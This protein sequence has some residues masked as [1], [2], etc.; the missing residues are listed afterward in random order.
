MKWLVS[1]L[2]LFDVSTTGERKEEIAGYRALAQQDLRVAAIGYRLA[3]T[4]RRYCYRTLAYNPGWVIHDIQQYPDA[5]IARAAFGFASPVEIS[6]IVPGGPADRSGLLAGDGLVRVDTQEIAALAASPAPSE[7]RLSAVRAL[8]DKNWANRSL[9]SIGIARKGVVEKVRFQPA[10][11]CKTYFWVDTQ[12][13]IDAGADGN[14]VR[15]TFAPDDD[16]LATALAHEMAHNLLGHRARLENIKKGKTRATLETEIE[17]DQLAIWLM[18]NAGYDP[19]AAPR[20]IER[21]GKRF[22]G[23][24]G[25][26]PGWKKRVEVMQAEMALI[27]QTPAK[28]GIREPPLLASPPT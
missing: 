5:N 9:F 3:S 20:F 23:T 21:Y 27:A 15:V 16:E 17:A 18:A 14:S 12:S 2:M 22:I 8:L 10:P 25:K 13:K 28:D 1:L 19:E 11:V 26:H 24:D 6:G 7:Q 4:N